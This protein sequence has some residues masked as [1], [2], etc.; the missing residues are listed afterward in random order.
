MNRRN[1]SPS[2]AL[3]GA[4]TSLTLLAGAAQPESRPPSGAAQAD[5]EQILPEEP[6]EVGA[7]AP[8]FKL[9]NAGGDWVDLESTLQRGPVVL[10]F[11]RGVWCPYCN[12]ELQSL[13]RVLPQIHE[14]GATV[15]ALSP[16]TREHVQENLEKNKLSFELLSDDDNRTAKRYG[17]AF[18]LDE[19][20]VDRYEGYGIDVATHNGTGKH[21]LP[22][23]ATYVIDSNGVIRFAFVDE[24]YKKRA[25]PKDILKALEAINAEQDADD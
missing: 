10:T 14:L 18:T 8:N 5:V 24:N 17:L 21:E 1:L 22:I 7:Q 6:L 23:P 3:A 25:K 15:L 2:L 20:T 9:R 4:L 13:E 16:E 19:R 12:N 11:Y